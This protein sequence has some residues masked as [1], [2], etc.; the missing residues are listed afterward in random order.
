MVHPQAEQTDRPGLQYIATGR[1]MIER[2]GD[3]YASVITVL[4]VCISDQ[5]N[6]LTA[7]ITP[8]K[9]MTFGFACLCHIC[10][11]AHEERERLLQRTSQ[12]WTF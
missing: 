3:K 1:W 6:T 7:D 5:N 8:T 4:L 9:N 12:G 2:H 10:R 11:L